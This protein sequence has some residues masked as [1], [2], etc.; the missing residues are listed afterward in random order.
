MLLDS[1]NSSQ[2][3]GAGQMNSSLTEA[4]WQYEQQS[5]RGCW[6][7]WALS[8]SQTEAAEQNGWTEQQ[9]D[10]GCWT[11]WLDWAH[12]YVWSSQLLESFCWLRPEK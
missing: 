12:V 6:T 2:T 11:V 5:D 10:R 7:V 3:K 8:S 9:S 4:A 1:M